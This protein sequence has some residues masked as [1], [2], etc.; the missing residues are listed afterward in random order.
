MRVVVKGASVDVRACVADEL[1]RR[2]HQAITEAA[3]TDTMS[4]VGP[5]IEVVVPP[6]ADEP[7][8]PRSGGTVVVRTPPVLGRASV[9]ATAHRF[10]GP[11]VFGVRGGANRT[12]FIHH[13]D[14]ARFVADAVERPCPAGEVSVDAADTVTLR[15]V[16]RLLGKPYLELDADAWAVLRRV[17]GLD[18]LA[19]A[20]GPADTTSA[21][22]L[23]AVAAWS[24][25]DCVTDFARAHRDRLY[26]GSIRLTIPWR[27]RWTP[28][29]PPL[30]RDG[31]PRHAAADPG[32]S[33]EFDT[34]VHPAYPEFT[35]ANVAEAF[36]GPMTP[37]SLELAMEALR[38]TGL[39]A[40]D[41]VQMTGEI[42]RAVTEEHVGCFGHNV[43]VNLTASRAASALL[44]AADPAGWRDFLFGAESGVENA[45]AGRI[46]AWGVIRRLPKIAVLLGAA[47]SET[48]RIDAEARRLQRGATHYAR[49]TDDQ[50]HTLLRSVRD[51]LADSWAVAALGSAGVVP[52]MALI[53]RLGGSRLASQFKG[54]VDELASAGLLRGTYDLADTARADP[55]I[56]ALLND[57]E[58]ISA[59]PRLRAEHPD[60][61]ARLDAVIAEYGHRG[62]RETELSGAVFADAPAR[63]LDAVVK[64]VDSPAR[65]VA[66]VPAM[67]PGLHLLARLGAGFQR[68]RERAR[69]AAMRHTH[70]YRLIA[71][72]L[73]AR[74]ADRSVVEQPSD[75]FYLLRDE[76]AHPPDD[77]RNR[78]ARRKAERAR[79]EN[80]RPPVYFARRWEPRRDVV[81]L[82]APGDGLTGIAASAGVAKGPVRILTAES[83]EDL[84]PGEVL[85]AEYTDT[86]WTP[87]FSHAGA[88]VVDTGAEMSHA[89]VIA[90]EFGIPCVV[91]AVTASRALRTGQVVEV[92]G[93]T[94]RVTRVE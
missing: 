42:R 8:S 19:P 90:R 74:L 17:P 73:G 53:R 59:L 57:T 78:V 43:Y 92:D 7:E 49:C 48:R 62:P 85:V 54:G 81:A 82:L 50:L 36:P 40:A 69:D 67:N 20:G 58:S 71:R 35:C 66:P 23:G 39:L 46:G 45:A 91:G 37:L 24:S 22:P 28:P 33:G 51:A 16:A 47:P 65:V 61:T 14:L 72:E 86:G 31:A 9:G 6:A 76:L 87:F 13:D 52:V 5:G 55:S 2:G 89:A 30:R 1:A 44:P 26:L 70:E 83:V 12:A 18:R 29:P 94:G 4:V 3:P 34:S 80:C 15:D 93:A 79:L 25:R 84:Q 27:F 88:V 60:F 32:V 38:A 77:V 75:V 21:A 68:S 11:I 64:L 41:I 56:T 10:G 63:L